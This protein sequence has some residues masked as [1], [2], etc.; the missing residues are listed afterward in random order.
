MGYK[1]R[2]EIRDWIPVGLLTPAERLVLLEIADVVNDDTRIGYPGMGDLVAMTGFPEK[3]VSACLRRL[4]SKG[5]EVRVQIGK[6]CD[7]QPLFA[8]KGHRT[9]YRIPTLAELADAGLE[10]APTRRQSPYP[11]GVFD[12][13]SPDPGRAFNDAKPLP[14]SPKAPTPV[15]QSPYPHL[16]KPLPG[17]G[18]SPQDHLKVPSTISSNRTTPPSSASSPTTATTPTTQQSK[19]IK[20]PEARRRAE[21]RAAHTLVANA[22]P[23]ATGDQIG[24]LLA[25]YENIAETAGRGRLQHISGYIRKIVENDGVDKLGDTL[26]GLIADRITHRYT[27]IAELDPDDAATIRIQTLTALNSGHGEQ[28]IR[29]ELD[30]V[31]AQAPAADVLLD[32]LTWLIEQTPEAV[33]AEMRDD[34]AGTP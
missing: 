7:G 3:T 24:L 1:L 2:R 34:H 32:S 19:R 16:L 28:A 9:T 20:N 27:T 10:A 4:S 11:G 17:S 5:I 21:H 13:Q 30:R 22:I 18:P 8:T 15:A 31:A 6:K 26:N 33:I 14:P 23:G 29:W 12:R 25:H